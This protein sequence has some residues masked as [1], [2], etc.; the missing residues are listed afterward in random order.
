MTQL[1]NKTI[2]VV[3]A[4]GAFGTSLALQLKDAGA[5]VYGTASSAA[6]SVRLGEHLDLR[7]LLDLEDSN[8]IEVLANY[9]L[10]EAAPLDAIILAS[11]LVGFGSI[12]ETPSGQ[13]ERLLKVNATG[14]IGLVQRLLPKLLESGLAEREPFVVSLSGVIAEA[15][16]P[17]LAAYSASKTALHGFAQ[18]AAK[19]LRKSRIRWIDARPGH[20]E[21]GLAGRAIFG[22]A[23]NFGEGMPVERVTTR[24]LRGILDDERDLP[25]SAF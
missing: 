23:P 4:T 19:E 15:P 24:I 12:A 7:L 3:G 21:S 6:S 22:T 17:G 1:Q 2:L 5:V 16:M 20:T 18:A 13:L 25:S 9:L 10:A 8:S 11:G 14:Q